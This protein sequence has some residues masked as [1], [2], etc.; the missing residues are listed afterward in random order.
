MAENITKIS[1]LTC[2]CAALACAFLALMSIK[3]AMQPGPSIDPVMGWWTL[4]WIGLAAVNAV[5]GA[6]KQL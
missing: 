2:R 1:A 3:A 5:M 4:V 6:W